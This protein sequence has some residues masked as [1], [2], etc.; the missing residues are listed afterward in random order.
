V[1]ILLDG[2]HG[3]GLFVYDRTSRRWSK[4]ADDVLGFAVT[5]SRPERTPE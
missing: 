5:N 2:E 4:I 3:Y 1:F